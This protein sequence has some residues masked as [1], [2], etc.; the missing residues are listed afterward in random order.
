MEMLMTRRL[1][2]LQHNGEKTW[3]LN[4]LKFLLAHHELHLVSFVDDYNDLQSINQRSPHIRTLTR[5]RTY[6]RRRNP[7][8]L[9]AV[10]GD[11]SASNPCFYTSVVQG[12][13]DALIKCKGIVV[14]VCSSLST[15]EHVAQ[16]RHAN[17]LRGLPKSRLMRGDK[18]ARAFTGL[19]VCRPDNA[20]SI[21]SDRWAMCSKWPR[22]FVKNLRIHRRWPPEA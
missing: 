13:V 7:L 21:G 22:C 8:A 12:H 20:P 14:L 9:P 11:G 10:A 16:S 6:F 1:S 5:L 3:M 19:R 2:C 17:Q 4:I 15:A 18:L